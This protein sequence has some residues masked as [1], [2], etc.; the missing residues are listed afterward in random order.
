M[1]VMKFG[2]HEV[3]GG[4]YMFVILIDRVPVFIWMEFSSIVEEGIC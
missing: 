4:M 1:S 3:G 2:G